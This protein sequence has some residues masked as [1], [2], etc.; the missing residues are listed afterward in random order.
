MDGYRQA[1]QIAMEAAVAAGDILRDEFH[2]P[3]GPRGTTDHAEADEVAEKLIRERLLETT[4][5]SYLGEET[6]AKAGDPGHMWLVDP[7]DGT[8]SYMEGRRGSAVSIAALRQGVP[9]L[10]VV[11][12]FAYPDDNGD[13]IAW[14][15]GCGPIMRNGRPVQCR[16]EDAQLQRGSIVL[17]SQDADKNPA[18]NAR[19]V[20]PG[21]FRSL[22]SIAYRLALVAAGEGVCAVSL[23]APGSWDYGG[24]HALIRAAGGTFVNES[25]HDIS[26]G[27]GGHS[28]TSRCFGGGAAAVK[29]L[30]ARP[31]DQVRDRTAKGDASPFG[32]VRPVPGRTIRNSQLLQHAQGCILGQLIGD[33]LGAQVEFRSGPSIRSEYTNGVRDLAG[34]G[35]YD[36][37]AGQP[38]DDSEMALM[39]ARCLVREGRYDAGA[40]LDAYLHWWDSSPFDYGGTTSAALEAAKR[41]KS[42]KQRLDFAARSALQDSEANGSLMRISPLGIFGW[43]NSVDAAAWARQDSGITHPNPACREACAALVASITAALGGADAGSCY[44]VSLQEAGRGGHAAVATALKRAADAP[45]ERL[46]DHR[47]G[48]VLIALQNAFYRLLHSESFE[49]A[50]VETLACGGDTDTNAAICGALLGAVHGREAIPA[51]WRHAVLTCRPM[52]EVGAR[53]ARP[54]DFWPVDAYELAEALLIAGSAGISFRGSA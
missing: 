33:A 10:G 38:T 37:L 54:A 4:N 1:L 45:P 41:G 25:G 11:Y 51:R 50:L 24:G 39:L 20:L 52:P 49:E 21:R 26:Y 15:E 19:C 35:P 40:A 8:S 12:A 34:G 18:A 3:G 6:G 36:T 32:L 53:H 27:A 7:N 43:S 44:Q 46:D 47:A 28:S 42:R 29:Q 13:L 2:R 30:V 9:V 5:W 23:H 17:I 14:A 48:W 31:W 16:L 22:P